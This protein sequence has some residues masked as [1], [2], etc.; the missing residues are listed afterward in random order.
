[1][2]KDTVIVICT[3][4]V[5]KICLMMVFV[6]WTWPI[7]H[8]IQKAPQ[9][10]SLLSTDQVLWCQS[11]ACLDILKKYTW[12]KYHIKCLGYIQ[13]YVYHI[14]EHIAFYASIEKIIFHHKSLTWC[15]T[16]PTSCLIHKKKKKKPGLSLIHP[17]YEC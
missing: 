5:E 11:K 10:A 1:M 8:I 7:I 14:C 4:E 12:N 17:A 2:L 6:P 3:L 15:R 9:I 13:V 16:S